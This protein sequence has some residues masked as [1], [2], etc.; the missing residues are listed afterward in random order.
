MLSD[1]SMMNILIYPFSSVNGSNG[2]LI[3]IQVEFFRK[4]EKYNSKYLERLLKSYK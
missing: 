2:I 4:L 3:K 1:K